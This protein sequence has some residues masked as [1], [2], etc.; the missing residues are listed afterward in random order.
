M[1]H[2][3]TIKTCSHSGK[4][5][6]I[7]IAPIKKGLAPS[8]DTMTYK[9]RVNRVLRTLHTMRTSAYES[10]LAR[11][12]SDAVERVGQIHAVR[13]AVLEPEDKVMLAVTF[14]GAWE[15]YIRVI[16]QKVSRL[17]DL[18]F[19]NTED[20]VVGWE[21]SYE[22]W[23]KWLRKSQAATSFLYATPALSAPDVRYLHIQERWNRRID[24]REINVTRIKIPSAEEIA[25]SVYRS[26]VDPGNLGLSEEISDKAAGTPAFRQ[27]LRGLV[28]LYRLADVY[29]PGTTDGKILG[30]AAIE[31][32]PEFVRMFEDG[33]TFQ[34][35]IRRARERFEEQVE[36]FQDAIKVSKEPPDA[37]RPPPL[38]DKPP[39]DNLA[40]IQ[41]GIL[42]SYPAALHGCLLL[43]AFDTAKALAEF[44]TTLQTTTAASKLQRG[45]IVTNI[46][47]TI[48]GMRLAGLSD[49]EIEALPKEFVQGMERRAGILGDLRV[50]HPRRWRLPARN[51]DQ[52]IDAKDPAENDKI[53]R[54]DLSAAHVA[55]QVRLISMDPSN[56]EQETIE[57]EGPGKE[58]LMVELKRLVDSNEGAVPLSLQWMRRYLDKS[59]NTIEHFG[60]IDGMSQPVLSKQAAG[61]VFKN[62]VHVGEVLHGYANAADTG[63]S[64]QSHPDATQALLHNGSFLVVRKLRQDIAV[65]DRVLEEAQNGAASLNDSGVLAPTRE[66]FLAKMMGRWPTGHVDAGKP[67]VKLPPKSNDVNDFRYKNDSQGKRCPFHAHIRRANPREIAPAHLRSFVQNGSRPP[68]LFRRG[69]TYGPLHDR[70]SDN[71]GDIAKS[72]EQERGLVFMA[73]NASIGEQFEV[74]QRWLS[75]GNGSDSYSGQSDPFLGTAEPGRRRYFRYEHE[76]QTVRMGLDG[77]DALH[78]DPQPLVRLEWGAY[79]FAPSISALRTLR[80]R[81]SAADGAML[82]SWSADIGERAIERLREIEECD[83]EMAASLAWKAALEDPDAATDFTSASIW[84]AIRAHH[85]GI[86][87]TPYGVLVVSKALVDEV[88]LD[89]DGLLTANGYVSRMRRSFGAIYLGFDAGQETGKYER[90]SKECNEA[91]LALDANEAYRLARESTRRKLNGLVDDAIRYA[92][93]DGESQWELTLNARGLIDEVLAQLCES[94]FGLSVRD[95]I[96]R[97][98]GYRWDWKEGDRPYYP[99]HFMAPSRY[100]FQPH[101]ESEVESIGAEHGRALR[102][103]MDEYLRRFGDEIDAPVA[104]AILDSEVN[105]G[106]A[107]FAARTLVGTIMGFVPTID[108]CL[109]RV[110]H[111]WLRDGTFWSLRARFANKPVDDLERGFARLREEFV[112][113]MQLRAAPEVLWR[114]ATVS[115]TIGKDEIHSVKVVPG[116]VV[117]AALV[118]ASHQCLEKGSS[119]LLHAFGGN[120]RAEE[121]PTHACPG[122]TA[123]LAVMMGFLNELVDTSQPLRVG[124]G[125][126]TLSMD[127][128]TDLGELGS[129]SLERF[130]F[131]AREPRIPLLAI[132]DSWVNKIFNRPS[133]RSS[134]ARLGYDV[135]EDASVVGWRLSDMAKDDTLEGVVDYLRDPSK[136]PAALLIGGGGND[137]VYPTSK[138]EDSAL[139]RMLR[140]DKYSVE[141]ALIKDEMNQ[142]VDD[143]LKALYT[144]I[145]DTLTAETD[146]PIL[147]HAYDHPIPDGR[148]AKV[149]RIKVGG[150]WL[151]PIFKSKGISLSIG[152]DVMRILIDRLNDMV[153]SVAEQYGEKIHHVRLC[154]VL[155]AHY[156]DPENYQQFWANELHPNEEGFDILA[157]VI[158]SKLTKLGIESTLQQQ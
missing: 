8:L 87:R 7:I 16:W 137:I 85:G 101:P 151:E 14:D 91:I 130:D 113:A 108:G 90:E 59:S 6:L 94:W 48:E 124:P 112:P 105:S 64:E 33:Q 20:Y 24:D 99:G 37:R 128:F 116:D 131:E 104:R 77:S 139:Y 84:A 43:A 27:G 145:L 63:P 34:E 96:F 153:N 98:G 3:I 114:T 134:L 23:D 4:S 67:L 1:R 25:D 109:R 69:M 125:P 107:D 127:G 88:L 129:E 5:D 57:E 140:K 121:H 13:I 10:E 46:G 79:L 111:E 144:K 123:A 86:L 74:V 93:D 21:A 83:G 126:L 154:D 62:Q 81:A 26:G 158:K 41:G 122:Y 32:L 156:G 106:D 78:E 12:L 29:P 9:T 11:V 53:E 50:N 80:D 58:R 73:Y 22:Q 118:S 30:S 155:A 72:L 66:D 70:S 117:I 136:P 103:A 51:W 39:I 40:D 142:F 61:R 143:E 76:G 75:G 135:N 65:L 36:W 68:R 146:L 102:A 47:L 45:Q 54:I 55:I 138:P 82:K 18:I 17:L 147:I 97:R 133:L 15:S 28:G 71:P 152:R 95:G 141:D 100:F 31:L 120:R 35:G 38:P 115:H 92:N 2:D 19:C 157:E 119:D 42:H 60:F 150:P 49:D 132:G 149:G 148:P 89:K 52:G 110:L 44:L 56:P